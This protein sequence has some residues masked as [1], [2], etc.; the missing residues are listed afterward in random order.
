MSTVGT[1]RGCSHLHVDLME[2]GRQSRQVHYGSC[3][4]IRGVLW[5][6]V[7]K[8][9]ITRPVASHPARPA[10]IADRT[11]HSPCRAWYSGG[12]RFQHGSSCGSGTRRRSKVGHEHSLLVFAT[13]RTLAAISVDRVRRPCE[14]AKE[15][16]RGHQH[17]MLTRVHVACVCAASTSSETHRAP[18]AACVRR[19][20]RRLLPALAMP[21]CAFSVVHSPAR[22]WTLV[23]LGMPVGRSTSPQSSCEGACAMAVRSML[24]HRP[25]TERVN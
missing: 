3:V 9:K 12:R 25:F 16:I 24:A 1:R 20:L 6:E 5:E 21:S 4:S 17:T 7:K 14:M 23:N 2:A 8:M 15:D 22:V 19:Q 18:H 13:S 10:T 11:S